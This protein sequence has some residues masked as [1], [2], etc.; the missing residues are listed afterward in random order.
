MGLLLDRP[1]GPVSTRTLPGG[2]GIGIRRTYGPGHPPTPNRRAPGA[3]LAPEAVSGMLPPPG[4]VPLQL[5]LR[6]QAQLGQGPG[7][8]RLHRA[9]ADAE[10]PPDLPG[11][12]AEA[13]E[14]GDLAFPAGEG[15]DPRSPSGRGVE[16]VDH[17]ADPGGGERPNR[18]AP[19]PSGGEDGDAPGLGDHHLGLAIAVHVADRDGAGRWA[20]EVRP[21]LEGSPAAPVHDLQTARALAGHQQVDAAV[22]V[23]V[24]RL[25][26]HR[27]HDRV[28]LLELPDVARPP[29]QDD[30][31]IREVVGHG[32]VQDPVAVEIGRRQRVWGRLGRVSVHSGR[33]YGNG[34]AEAIRDLAPRRRPVPGAGAGRLASPRP[35][36][37][38]PPRGLALVPGPTSPWWQG[39]AGSR[40]RLS[41]VLRVAED[42]SKPQGVTRCPSPG[43]TTSASAPGTSRSPRASIRR[44]SGRSRFRPPTSAS[45]C[46]GSGW[47]TC[48][49]T[50]S[51]GRR[52]PL[53]TR[54][55]PSRSRTWTGCTG[56]R[57]SGAGPTA[58]PSPTTSTSCREVRCSSTSGTQPATWSR[59]TTPT[60][61]PWGPRPG[62]TCAGSPTVCPR[63]RR[64]SGPG[65]S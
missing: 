18:E 28:A 52:A 7:E 9:S 3:A 10:Q 36:R 16:P 1:G 23:Q 22:P 42:G 41:P 64:T 59:S 6:L 33:G 65:S 15:P 50:S 21:R 31:P 46:S 51:S 40:P 8:V 43:S 2:R 58:R 61:P 54:T 30:D 47:A 45:R 29:Q 11:A 35:A 56:W 37:S 20:L 17:P 49:C 53:A 63:A 32:Q 14:P 24:G 44:S 60:P 13:G 39:H 57:R 25:D 27:A 34:G 4:G 26:R 48:S 12:V 5:S 38:G 55:W 62:P 19:A